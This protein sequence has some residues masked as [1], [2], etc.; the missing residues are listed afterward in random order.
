MFQESISILPGKKWNISV[1][2]TS[3]TSSVFEFC[4]GYALWEYSFN[5]DMTLVDDDA[6]FSID[7]LL[8]CSSLVATPNACL[9]ISVGRWK[10]SS[11][12]AFKASRSAFYNKEGL[13]IIIK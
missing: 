6:S 11:V 12:V 7:C 2:G 8:S 3:P 5:S 4:Q 1:Y 9:H 13:I 10:P